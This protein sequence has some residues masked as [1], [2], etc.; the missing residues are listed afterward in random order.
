MELGFETIG[1]AT[2]ICH[3]RGPVLVTDPWLRGGAY[4]ESWG[5]SHEIP[6]EQVASAL[7]CPFV[8]ISHG[9]PD[10]LSA[11]SLEAFRGRTVLVPD[12]RAG[13]IA[14]ELRALGFRV[15]VLA[16]RRWRSLSER[17]RIACVADYNQ[18][19]ILLA[20]VG[21]RLVVDLNDASDRGWGGF[22]RR[23]VRRFERSFLL[24]LANFG[25]ADM[26]NFRDE[27]GRLLPPVPASRRWPI[28]RAICEQLRTFGVRHFI[29]FS[30]LH[31]YRRADSIWANAHVATFADYRE[32]FD[33]A[34]GEL[35]PA[36]IRWD[37]LRDAF[38]EI[39]PRES[40]GPVIEP[41]EAGDDWSEPLECED[42]PKLDRYFR[43]FEHLATFL[44][45][46]AVRIGGREHVVELARRR[47]RRGVTFE[48]PRCSFLSAVENE[49]F[50]DLLIG[51]FARATLHG[52]WPERPFYPDFTPFVAKYGDNGRAHTKDELEEYFRAYRKRAPLDYILH[53]AEERGKSAFRRSVDERSPIYRIAKRAYRAV[54]KVA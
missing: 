50:D 22:V 19:A 2:L 10:H 28:G 3:D 38:D 53:V 51:N 34:A 35:L 5:L 32:G 41:A 43:S 14:D 33:P 9:H 21:G 24:A 29:P 23:T 4:F 39:R 30:S 44:D 54:R 17:V 48:S 49:V 13:R 25:D 47:F 45:F 26:M 16:D 52:R 12:H 46:V 6:D 37:C 15:E 31:R 36:F 40:V 7:A 1:N 42:G 18:D 8:W 11:A 20:D 27:D